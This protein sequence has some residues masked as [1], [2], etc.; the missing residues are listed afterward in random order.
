MFYQQIFKIVSQVFIYDLSSFVFFSLLSI[1]SGSFTNKRNFKTKKFSKCLIISV[2]STMLH[3]LVIKFRSLSFS[4]FFSLKK[5]IV[6]LFVINVNYS[7]AITHL[8][9]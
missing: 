2:H 5:K 6:S 1:S 4:S 3:L 7:M 9:Q 8:I